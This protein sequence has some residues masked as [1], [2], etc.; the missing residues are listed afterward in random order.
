VKKKPGGQ[1]KKAGAFTFGR[2]QS[3]LRLGGVAFPLQDM[4]KI[5]ALIQLRLASFA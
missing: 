1:K 3:L 5:R 4:V 2:M